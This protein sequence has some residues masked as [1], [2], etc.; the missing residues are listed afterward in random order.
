LSR[1]NCHMMKINM[2]IKIIV[3]GLLLLGV[4]ITQAACWDHREV[5]QLGIVMATGV[6]SAAGG[7]VRIIMQNVNPT[8]LGKG[9]GGGGGGGPMGAANKPYRN[10]SI[11]GDTIS[12]A[13]RDASREAPRQLFFAHN[14]VIILSEELVRKRGL[15]EVVDF[16]QRDPHMRRTTWIIVGRGDLAS[17]LD[18]PGQLET[19]PAQRIDSIIDQRDRTS[20]YAV[21]RIGDF[22]ELL[23]SE[24]T[25]P[26]TAV[27]ETIP[28]LAVPKDPRHGM[29]IGQIPEPPEIIRLNGTA[30]FRRDKMVGWLSQYESRGL[31]WVRGEVKGGILEIPSPDK[32]TISIALEILR[33]KTKLQ[34]E[35]RNGQIYITVS[36]REESNLEETLVP[37]DLTKPE[38]IKKLEELQAEAIRKEIESALAKAQQEYGVDVFGFGE[39][40]HRKYPGEWKEMKKMWPELFPGVQVQV[41]VETKIRR[42]GLVTK[43]VEPMQW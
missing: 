42:T 15:Q 22:L 38:T 25:Q 3:L 30:V 34:P 23:E 7:R 18:E 33:S 19:T 16:F 29:S 13:I 4:M 26:F 9:A 43:P 28:N 1:N 14:Q 8:A 24:S 11:E 36:V 12:E 21:Q 27:V 20:E 40:V 41:Q 37:L 39:A 10:R 31:L 5:E 17:L 2:I 32:E 35:I 6:E